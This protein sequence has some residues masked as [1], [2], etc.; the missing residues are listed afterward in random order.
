MNK[1]LLLDTGL[2][3][4]YAMSNAALHVSPIHK[5]HKV[6]F[7]EDYFSEPPRLWE[8]RYDNSYPNV[9]YDEEEK[10]YRLYYSV[11]TYD[12]DA[13]RTSLKERETKQ[14]KPTEDRIVSL[15]Y[16]ES[17]DGIHWEKPDLYLHEIN[18]DKK[19]NVLLPYAHGT[20][21]FL[22]LEEND[23]NKRYKMMTKIDYAG[24]N[25]FMAVAFSRDGIHFTEPR[26]WAKYNP[27]A[28][29]HN[30]VFRDQRTNRFVLI[31]RIWRNGLRIVAKSES[32]DFINW[33]EPQEVYRGKGFSNQVYSMPVFQ[34]ANLYLGL[35]SIY[36][37]GDQMDENYDTVDCYLKF[38]TNLDAWDSIDDDQPFIP[39]GMG[40]YPTGEPDCGCIYASAPVEIDGRMYFYY[41]GGNGQHTN[42]RETSFMRGYVEK[43]Q[44]AYY[45]NKREGQDAII[46]TTAFDVYG[47]ELKV[48]IDEDENFQL[49]V[50][51]TN[52][53]GIPYEGFDASNLQISTADKE[54]YRTITY[55]EHTISELKGSQIYLRFTFQNVK[56]FA[57]QGDL[58]KIKKKY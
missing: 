5:E 47:D 33:S 28:D 22:D 48:L 6:L 40:H 35:A 55:K 27:Q 12:K 44:F 16:A 1:F 9:I 30:F 36:H 21:V 19:N 2:I 42:F 41:M 4:G 10:L 50:E 26:E 20:S 45:T 34:Y 8:V 39:R 53:K 24:N 17:K 58:S 11:F 54:G 52:R 15:C 46:Q 3:D 57:I 23:K 32:S 18:G 56:L 13:A 38:T 25:N 7:H 37:E 43:D 49:K 29:T 31:T 51:I 14:Y